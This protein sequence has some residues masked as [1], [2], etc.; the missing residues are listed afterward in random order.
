MSD[1]LSPVRDLLGTVDKALARGGRGFAALALG[2]AVGW[3]V[4][5]PL[6]ELLHALGC[7]VAGG[8]VTRLDIDTLYGGALL[9]RLFPFVHAGSEYAGRLAGFDTHGS[10]VVYLATDL[11]PF[12]LALFPGVWLL[13]RMVRRGRAFAA[14]AALPFAFASYLSLSGDAYEIGSLLVVQLPAW[15]S[16]RELVG[17]DVL[18]KLGELTGAGAGVMVGY[19]LAILLGVAWAVAWYAAASWIAARG[20]EPPLDLSPPARALD[21]G[22]R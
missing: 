13:R 12:L 14:G 18:R 8:S 10:D 3:W 7:R 5:V 22:P 6:H 4:Y 20:G 1:F 2:L 9:A 21:P 16:H 17:D 19:A 11:A 15:A